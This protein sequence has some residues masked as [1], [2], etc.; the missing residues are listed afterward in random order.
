MF[1]YFWIACLVPMYLIWA[2]IS[3][4]DIIVSL[5]CKEDLS[6][7]STEWFIAIHIAVPIG[8]SFAMWLFS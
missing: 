8:I 3:I 2:A 7:I 5:R 6:F 1:K 4:V